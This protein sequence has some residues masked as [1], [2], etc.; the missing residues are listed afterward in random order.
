MLGQKGA[1]REIEI[2]LHYGEA[3]CR[4]TYG[5]LGGAARKR[6]STSSTRR[7]RYR[8]IDIQRSIG[9]DVVNLIMG[10]VPPRKL[11]ISDK[12]AAL[13]ELKVQADVGCHRNSRR[14]HSGYNSALSISTDQDGEIESR[15]SSSYD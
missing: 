7:Q 2:A 11:T 5:S 12:S 4:D 3:V 15:G 14:A 10:R 8:E 1:R 6:E 13:H 9:G